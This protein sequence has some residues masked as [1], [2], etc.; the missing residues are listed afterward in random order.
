MK[1]VLLV[2]NGARE[3]VIAEA[4]VRGGAIL[5]AFMGKMNP[6]IA[7][8]CNH[9]VKIGNL[10]EFSNIGQFAKKNNIDFIV[11]GPENPLALGITNAMLAF[12]IPTI[13]PTIE[14]AQLE[15]SKI[16]MRDLLKKYNIAANIEFKKFTS[17]DG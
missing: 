4:L 2:G 13:G 14:C 16:F 9:N 3:H 15:S 7:D 8:L 1:K 12:D 5:Y 10:K 17:M 11:V 6:G